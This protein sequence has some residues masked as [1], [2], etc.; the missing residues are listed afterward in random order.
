MGSFGSAL[1]AHQS[2]RI[3]LS[4]AAA[5][6]TAAVRDRG[7]VY[8]FSVP[9]M[10]LPL[11]LRFRLGLGF[12]ILHRNRSAFDGDDVVLYRGDRA[13]RARPGADAE[14]LFDRLSNLLLVRYLV[15]LRDERGGR[16]Q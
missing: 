15:A 6:P 1:V 3:F 8:R 14:A 7:A 16:L 10:P 2:I 11:P 9:R 4:S 13:T 12:G 5:L